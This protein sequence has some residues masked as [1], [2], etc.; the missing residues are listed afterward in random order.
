MIKLTLIKKI[1]F[2]IQDQV[3]CAED[4]SLATST[5]VRRHTEKGKNKT[6]ENLVEVSNISFRVVMPSDFETVKNFS[7]ATSHTKGEMALYITVAFISFLIILILIIIKKQA[8]RKFFV[9][10]KY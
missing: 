2:C 1:F 9:W 8:H 4:Q 6:D 7:H 10:D 5:R 3:N